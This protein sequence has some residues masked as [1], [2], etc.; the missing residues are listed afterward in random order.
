[1][2]Q[3]VLSYKIAFSELFRHPKLGAA[4][5]GV[6]GQLIAPNNVHVGGKRVRGFVGIEVVNPLPY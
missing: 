3:V 2:V 5:A 6:I 1:M 4:G